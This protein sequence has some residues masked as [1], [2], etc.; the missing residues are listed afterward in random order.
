MTIQ[1][2]LPEVVQ[3]FTKRENI[4]RF[5]RLYMEYRRTGEYADVCIYL[6]LYEM[7]YCQ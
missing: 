6:A 4:K 7:G 2:T 5:V 1:C 3:F